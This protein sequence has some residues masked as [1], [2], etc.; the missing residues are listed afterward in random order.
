MRVDHIAEELVKETDLTEKQSEAVV[1]V[2]TDTLAAA[3][4]TGDAMPVMD[5]DVVTFTME[6]QAVLTPLIERAQLSAAEA[7]EVLDVLIR[8]L[9]LT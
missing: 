2:V 1:D 3:L 5:N 6:R 7:S 8:L 4:R 9:S